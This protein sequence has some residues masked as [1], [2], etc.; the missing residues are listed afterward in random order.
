MS[1]SLRDEL[2]VVLSRDQVKL[3]R[4]GRQLTLQ[5]IYSRVLEKKSIAY[6]ADADSSWSNAVKTLAAALSELSTKQAVA[7]VILSNHFVRYAMV[8][9]SQTLSN[10]AEELAYAKHVFSQLYGT[11]AEASEIRLHQ[12]SAGAAQLAS[13][14]DGQFLRDVRAVFAAANVKLK[15]VQP[16]LMTAYNNC[17]SHIPK[18]DAWFA[19]F[20]QGSLCLGLV[21]QGQ[22]C[23]LR[24]I[25]VGADWLEKLPELLDRET[26]L[27]EV[28][29]L[30]DEI[31]LWAPEY[32]KTALPKSLK[33]KIHKLQPAIRA[34]FAADYD[35]RFALAML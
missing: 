19:V 27:S 15:S 26:Y 30:A 29:T 24:A 16:Q 31:F 13:A 21:Q 2:R 5:G 34:S 25:K 6:T 11:S 3:V 1:L 17:H 8:A 20:E 33:W 18:Q 10:E 9:A 28:D 14:V 23:S 22:W 32:W 4:I 12:G 35:E 7:S